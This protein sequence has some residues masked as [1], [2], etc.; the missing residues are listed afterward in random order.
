MGQIYYLKKEYI[1]NTIINLV[2]SEDGQVFAEYALIISLLAIV[3]VVSLTLFGEE[4]VLYY[5]NNI[6]SNLP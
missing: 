4:L 2:R 5:Q 6:V 3:V 1:M